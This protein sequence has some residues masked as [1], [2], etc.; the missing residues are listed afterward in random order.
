MI[1][2]NDITFDGDKVTIHKEM[3]PMALDTIQSALDKMEED[4]VW[5]GEVT[6]SWSE[7]QRIRS[8]LIADEVMHSLAYFNV[9]NTIA[10]KRS[11]R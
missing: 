9:K 8:L 6:L 5:E 1:T 2:K 11:E 10:R 4:S 3:K 7:M